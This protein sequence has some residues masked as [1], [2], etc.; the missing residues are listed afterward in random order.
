M[1]KLSISFL[2]VLSVLLAACNAAA[3]ATPTATSGSLATATPTP[4]PT[5]STPAGFP[6]IAS[7]VEKVGPAVV[8]VLATVKQTNVFGQTVTGT[9]QGSG[10]I[11][12]KD[13]YILTNNHVV[14]GATKV[15][16]AHYN[17][18]QLEAQ[19][20][21]TDPETD[22][23]VLK[24]DPSKIPDMVVATLGDTDAMRIGD[25]VIAIGSPL[26]YEGSVT[27][28]I[29]SA[30]GRSLQVDPSKPMLHDLVQTD[31]VINP[32]NSG[33][34]LLNL[35]GQVIGINTAIIQGNIGNNQQAYGIGFAI[36]MGTAKP[37]A[38]QLIKN[39]RV[40]RPRLGVTV[41]D[42]TPVLAN[43][44]GLSVNQGALV[45][46]VVTGGPADKAGIKPNDVIVQVDNT[47]ITSTTELVRLV[48]LGSYKVG[49]TVNVTVN[50]SGTTMSFEV[51][52]EE[53]N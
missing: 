52:L 33:G 43:E 11:F 35:N 50:R 21:G 20:V 32:G 1:R 10:V 45:T 25:W 27:V 40:I 26:G 15:E 22:L 44:Q 46:D 29:V 16:I 48:S 9:S 39:G 34:P 42:V 30:K 49:D 12:S 53:V 19:V 51:T 3:T 28:G 8:Q 37:V 24:I 41:A 4:E 38:D 7:V 14:E 31:A 47:P 6:D 5:M 13:G 2:L 36:S 23:A 17:Q 18:E